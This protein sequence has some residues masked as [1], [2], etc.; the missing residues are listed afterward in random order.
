MISSTFCT[1]G[2][3]TACHRLWG[4]K[5]Q[6]SESGYWLILCINDGEGLE[7]CTKGIHPPQSSLF[8][9]L[10]WPHCLLDIVMCP[11]SPTFQF[12]PHPTPTLS[13]SHTL[14]TYHPLALL[15]RIWVSTAL[16]LPPALSSVSP[17]QTLAAISPDKTHRAQSVLFWNSDLKSAL[18]LPVP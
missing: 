14:P 18:H 6:L 9:S 17:R 1:S 11:I 15:Y 4:S 5:T 2:S 7:L 8:P 13:Q 3:T 10:P 16:A 12:H